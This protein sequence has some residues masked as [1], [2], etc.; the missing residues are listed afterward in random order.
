[1][2]A[3]ADCRRRP[4]SSS[5]GNLELPAAYCRRRPIAS[6]SGNLEL[7]LFNVLIKL[8]MSLVYELNSSSLHFVN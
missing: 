7:N 8:H 6:S 5:S 1:L 3:A 4:I 2:P